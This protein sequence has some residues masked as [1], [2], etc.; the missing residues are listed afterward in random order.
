MNE[1]RQATWSTCCD[2]YRTSF[3]CPA[4]RGLLPAQHACVHTPCSLHLT[5]NCV[6]HPP[7]VL[8]HVSMYA[9]TSFIANPTLH[10]LQLL[11]SVTA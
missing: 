8:C 7:Q 6:H 10:T 3:V 2:E 1:H 4:C 9:L 11:W 5:P